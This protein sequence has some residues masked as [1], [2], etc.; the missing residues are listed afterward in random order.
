[1]IQKPLPWS[2]ALPLLA[3]AACGGDEGASS[4]DFKGN[5]GPG[6]SLE[7]CPVFPADNPWN[8][9]ISS[10]P[11]DPRSDDYVDSIGRDTN[12]HPDFGR[13][14]GIPYAAVD[15]SVQKVSVSFNYADESD[16]GPY[17]IPA[18]P[19]IEDG[20]DAH[21]LLIQTDE[22]KLYEIF[23]ASRDGGGWSGGSGAIFDLRSNDL[24]PD[25]WTSADAAGLP[26]FAGLARHVDVEAGEVT[27][28][29][30]F[31]ASSTQS[32]YA[33]PARH[34]AGDGDDS[35]LPP[36]GLRMRLKA[37][38]DVSRFSPAAQ[39]IMKGLKKYGMFLADNGSDW[40]ITGAPDQGWDDE[41]DGSLK[42]LRGD[43][44]EAIETGPLTP[45]F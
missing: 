34:S 41:T 10:A 7:G 19:P 30:R 1:M 33:A 6:T 22:C 24:R 16:P 32:A 42:E 11:V 37:S 35:S 9:D 36:M 12:I 3:L 21:I 8:T 40:Y 18:N 44:F 45:G 2:F 17:P 13:D 26:I 28:A 15:D 20:G 25:G 29:L 23:A 38:F 14:F 4:T 27:H 5:P 31:T 39:I 43:D